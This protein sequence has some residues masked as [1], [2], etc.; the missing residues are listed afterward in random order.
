MSK[1]KSR[2]NYDYG[3]IFWRWHESRNMRAGRP[4]TYPPSSLLLPLSSV[5]QL[6]PL[7]F[8]NNGKEARHHPA[9]VPGYR[10]KKATRPASTM[11]TVLH[12]KHRSHAGHLAKIKALIW[13]RISAKSW[14]N[15]SREEARSCYWNSFPVTEWFDFNLWWLKNFGYEETM[16]Y[17]YIYAPERGAAGPRGQGWGQRLSQHCQRKHT[18]AVVVPKQRCLLHC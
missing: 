1:K 4:R 16:A 8:G 7:L 9:V 11:V 3:N 18:D 14:K 15:T 10:M 6:L 2:E 5:H 13:Y 12:L 17:L